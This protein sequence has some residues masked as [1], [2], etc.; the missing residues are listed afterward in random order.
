ME[1]KQH[2]R[3]KAIGGGNKTLRLTYALMSKPL[4]YK[5]QNEIKLDEQARDA[6]FSKLV[7]T[8][9]FDSSLGQ[10]WT[11]NLK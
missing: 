7:F 4:V 8:K 6:G 9:G 3:V 10:T 1:I 11:I 5:F 2:I